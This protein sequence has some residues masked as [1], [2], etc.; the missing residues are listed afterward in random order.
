MTTMSKIALALASLTCACAFDPVG[1]SMATESSSTDGGTLVTTTQ[2]TGATASTTSSATTTTDGSESDATSTETF[3]DDATTTYAESSTGEVVTDWAL[4][5]DG[6]SWARSADPIDLGLTDFTIETWI[7][8]LDTDATGIIVDHQDDAY[9]NGWVLYLHSD[10]HALVF[11]FF[12]PTHT[13][14]VVWGP[15]VDQIGTGWHHIAIDKV[16]VDLTIHVDGHVTTWDTVSAEVSAGDL[17]ITIGHHVDSGPQFALQN[18]VV[19]DI[20][21]TNY[22][23]YFDADFVPPT[24]LDADDP[25][26]MALLLH[27]DEGMGISTSDAEISETVFSITAPAWVAGH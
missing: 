10:N 5:F 24:T 22:S 15:A 21:I 6:T 20:R 16:D 2:T 14:Q 11:S 12:D 9:L 7:E 18:A 25:S 19:D 8:I 1:E 4:A 26:F 13:N 17:D 3:G 27:L 23:R